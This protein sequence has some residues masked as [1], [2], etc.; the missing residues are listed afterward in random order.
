MIK[1]RCAGNLA[2]C[3]T[4]SPRINHV[5]FRKPL[6]GQ[7]GAL[8]P[9]CKN[10]IQEGRPSRSAEVVGVWARSLTCGDDNRLPIDPVHPGFFQPVTAA[11]SVNNSYVNPGRPAFPVSGGC[12]HLGEEP[13]RSRGSSPRELLFLPLP[14]HQ[15]ESAQNNRAGAGGMA[16]IT[17]YYVI[18]PLTT[19]T[20]LPKF[21]LIRVVKTKSAP[22]SRCAC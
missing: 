4:T 13:R 11:F 2:L 18:I 19:T 12:G 1:K 21:L 6:T 8:N 20:D 14:A 22:V 16:T 9:T 10:H 7:V 17:G 5:G 15:T 3:F